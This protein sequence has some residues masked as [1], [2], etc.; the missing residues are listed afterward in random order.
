[1]LQEKGEQDNDHFPG[2]GQGPGMGHQ[3]KIF[4]Q[5]RNQDPERWYGEG[6]GGGFRM[7]N[8]CILVDTC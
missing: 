8:T 1:M 6:G 5:E 2:L 7:R 3:V 4:T